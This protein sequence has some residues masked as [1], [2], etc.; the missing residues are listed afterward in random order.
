[1]LA[2]RGLATAVDALAERAPV[3]VRIDISAEQLPASAERTAY[4]VI[5]E[6]LTNVAK[7]A[8]ATNAQVSITRRNG[9]ACVTI[10]DDG[11]GGAEI[12]AGSGL[13]GLNDRVAATGGTLKISSGPGG[14]TLEATIPCE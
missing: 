9:V 6:G 12:A 1:M 8:M 5:A 13:E 3:P 2:E 11:R 4:Y 7:H 14:T 10:R